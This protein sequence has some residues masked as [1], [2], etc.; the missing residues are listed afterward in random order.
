MMNWTAK[1]STKFWRLSLKGRTCGANVTRYYMYEHLKRVGESLPNR[2][3]D[4][5]SISES[6]R[7]CKILRVTPRSLVEANYPD[8]NL[9][10]LQFPD[11]SFDFVFSDQVLEHV[12]GDPQQAVDESWRVLRPGGIALHTTCFIYQL[13]GAPSDYWRFSAD[14]L[15]LLA[16][17]FSRVLDCDSWGNFEASRLLRTDFRFDGIPHAKWHPLHHLAM[18]ND[19]S[20]PIVSWIVAQK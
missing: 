16:R 7:L 15:R 11:E 13:H 12:G 3:G 20:W 9:L 8:H 6:Q 2:E 5:L 4:V 19:P 10:S 18:R 14:A 17:R 1:V